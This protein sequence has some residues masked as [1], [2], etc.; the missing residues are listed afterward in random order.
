MA[1][2]PRTGEELI[3]SLHDW[4]RS[5][6]V[7]RLVD[8]RTSEATVALLRC[9]AGEEVDRITSGDPQWLEYLRTRSSSEQ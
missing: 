2:R 1:D 9:D 6:A 8:I 5:G 3:G 7:W 4:E